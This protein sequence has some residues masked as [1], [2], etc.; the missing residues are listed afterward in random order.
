MYIFFFFFSSRG[1]HTRCSRDW[2][3]DVCSS[4][5]VP[6]CDTAK[7]APYWV[8]RPLD[9]SAPDVGR[10][11]PMSIVPLLVVPPLVPQAKATNVATMRTASPLARTIW[12]PLVFVGRHEQIPLGGMPPLNRRP[13]PNLSRGESAPA[14]K[15][16]TWGGRTTTPW[17]TIDV[18]LPRSQA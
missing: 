14:A 9:A 4:D 17:G 2:S 12:F 6:A 5:L 16:A 15:A 1:R 13:L 3:S 10:S 18:R 7:A 8:G 11:L